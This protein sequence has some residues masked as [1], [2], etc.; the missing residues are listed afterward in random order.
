MININ[1]WDLSININLSRYLKLK[2]NKRKKELRKTKTY[3][4]KYRKNKYNN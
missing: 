3:I 1:L 2:N 4:T